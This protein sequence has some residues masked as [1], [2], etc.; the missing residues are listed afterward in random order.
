MLL[1]SSAFVF[2]QTSYIQ[3]NGE[4]GLS[5]YLNNQFKGKTTT[6]Y[7]GLIIENVTAGK[8]L[9][10]IEKEGFTPFEEYV[11]V[12]PGEVFSYKVKAFAKHVVNISEQGNS[13]ETENKAAIKTGDLI[14]QSVPIEIKI[15]IPDI[16]GI[17]NLSKTKDKWLA[18]KIPAGSYEI[19]FTF[20]GKVIN[21]RFDI[22]GNNTTSVFVN[23]LNGEFNTKNSQDEKNRSRR[24][25]D[26]ILNVSKF[27]LLIT[28]EDFEKRYPES[29]VTFSL[30]RS[31]VEGGHIYGSVFSSSALCSIFLRNNIVNG[32]TYR[33]QESKTE[34]ESE[35]YYKEYQTYFDENLVLVDPESLYG[36]KYKIKKED[37]Y[38]ICLSRYNNRIFVYYY[39]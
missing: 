31:K 29:G 22:V 19:T 10:K 12:K 35:L 15:T 33:I 9:I 3:V 20:N 38:Y 7:K 11:N 14:I 6:E 2:A 32:Y 16:E 30:K 25:T 21:K 5:V 17:D 18:D 36:R 26:S 27:Q 8:N 13:G 28:K 1:L 34:A 4:P 23:M 37:T 24:I 39:I